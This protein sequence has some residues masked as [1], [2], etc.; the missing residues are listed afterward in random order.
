MKDFN[1]YENYKTVINYCEDIKSGKI[2]ANREQIQGIERFLNMLDDDRYE[3]R[4]SEPEIIIKLIEKTIKHR[5]ALAQV[6]HL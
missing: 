1:K 6:H 4:P 2:L 5:Q 3:L